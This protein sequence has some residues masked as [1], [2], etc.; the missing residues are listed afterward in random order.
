VFDTKNALVAVLAEAP[1]VKADQVGFGGEIQTGLPWMSTPTE[2]FPKP[3]RVRRPTHPA[4]PSFYQTGPSNT[5][6][7]EAR[8]YPG[9]HGFS[10]YLNGTWAA[11]GMP[12]R[13]C[14]WPSSPQNTD[15]AGLTYRVKSW[16]LG[17]FSKRI[18]RCTTTMALSTRRWPSTLQ[19]DQPVPQ[20]HNQRDS[21]TRDQDPVGFTNFLDKH[22]IVGRGTRLGDSATSP[23]TS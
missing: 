1:T 6:G 19:R 8:A 9:R 13:G 4:S 14:M 3:V 7:V 15:T 16:D 20:L 2:P 10:V 5:K 17:F 18:V 22:S 23:M 11:R 21:I 12:R